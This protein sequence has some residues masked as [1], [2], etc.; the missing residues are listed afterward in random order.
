[1][2]LLL[3]FVFL[4]LIQ[5]LLAGDISGMIRRVALD[6]PVAILGMIATTIIVDK[7]L[8]LTDALSAAVL[9]HSG[10]QAVHFLS[11]FGVAVTSA[12]QGFAAVMLGLVAIV[13]GFF[14][15]VEL[16]VRSVLVYILVALSPLTFAAMVWPAA[17][18]M[19]R[20]TVELSRGW[21]TARR[22]AWARC[23]SVPPSWRWPRSRRSWS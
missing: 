21:S 20:R 14:V 17:R 6:L 11:G 15:W 18:G 23:S 16:I 1:L 13:A 22:R 3:G 7:L 19:L 8:Q 10:D 4:G 12:T 2:A 9:T 5:G